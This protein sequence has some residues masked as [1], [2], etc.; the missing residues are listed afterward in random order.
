MDAG[1]M[2]MTMQNPA[3]LAVPVNTS[4]PVAATMPTVEQAGSNFA[5][6]LS[7]LSTMN[8]EQQP[9]GAAKQEVKVVPEKRGKSDSLNQTDDPTA[10]ATSLQVSLGA[11]SMLIP[12]AAV[13]NPNEPVKSAGEVQSVV[14]VSQNVASG[15]CETQSKGGLLQNMGS[16]ADQLGGPGTEGTPA[17]TGMTIPLQARST[18]LK[19]EIVVQN[20]FGRQDAAVN[21]ATEQIQAQVDGK[22][23]T[24]G[25]SETVRPALEVYF[26]ASPR[27]VDSTKTAEVQPQPTETLSQVG[28]KVT[29]DGSPSAISAVETANSASVTEPQPTAVPEPSVTRGA[30]EAVRPALEAYF[31]TSPRPVGSTKTAEVSAQSTETL[32]QVV[33]KVSADGLPSTVSA[34]ETAN[35]ASVTERTAVLTMAPVAISVVR[36]DLAASPTVMQDAAVNKTT[37]TDRPQIDM[38]RPAAMPEPSVTKGASEVVRPALEAYFQASPRPVDSTKTAEVQPQPTETL[39]QVGQKVTADGSPST[40]SA[41]GTA[42]SASV[43]ERTAVSAVQQ[44]LTA[45]PIDT[46]NAAVNKTTEPAQAQG[47][48]VRQALM[49]A[50][51]LGAHAVESGRQGDTGSADERNQRQTTSVVAGKPGITGNVMAGAVKEVASA[52]SGEKLAGDGNNQPDQKL[53]GNANL[54]IPQQAKAENAATTVNTP[55]PATSDVRPNLSEHVARQV[56]EHLAGHE[57][58]KGSDQ[59]V[60]RLTPE[61]LGELKLNL[62]M[63][64]QRLNVEIVTENRAVKDM[65]LQH[66]DSLRE[67]LARQNISMESFDVTTG[68]NG[69]SATGRGQDDWR[70]LARQ[71]QDNAWMPA[72]G[73][74][75][76]TSVSTSDL[77]SYLAKAAYSMVDLHF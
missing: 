47:S 62:R 50:T 56:T 20:E 3:G 33:Q 53:G 41:V 30:S 8:P 28:Q 7:V 54:A 34:V 27:P 6:V 44:N 14:L 60:I 37:E 49:G 22:V 38:S 29:A 68:G 70:E 72:G 19:T 40:V 39:P 21:K 67:S 57:I 48:T 26:Q 76:P 66:S 45:S 35:S 61:N 58:K 31:Q 51:A 73:Y 16:A 15:I 65:I 46:Q 1:Q 64:G 69:G 5:D 63:D 9:T 18:G 74:R 2:N 25:A 10:L 23:V 43:T 42:N 36:Q 59:I 71:R 32:P 12:M 4:V 77:P 52:A 13:D 17:T 55:A 11:G 75:M 24:K